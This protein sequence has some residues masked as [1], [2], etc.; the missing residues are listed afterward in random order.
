MGGVLAPPFCKC[1]LVV[2]LTFGLKVRRASRIEMR[3]L[4]TLL[5]EQMVRSL[6]NI[7]AFR[8]YRQRCYIIVYKNLH[9]CASS[10]V[11]EN[12]YI[13]LYSIVRGL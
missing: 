6:T 9:A 7:A 2:G 5:F 8:A 1:H 11:R 3:L 10:R 12:I 13:L 4:G